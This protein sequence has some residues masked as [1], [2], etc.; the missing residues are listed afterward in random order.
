MQYSSNV[1]N[2][3]PICST[4]TNS[5]ASHTSVD[6]SLAGFVC[7][8][9]CTQQLHILAVQGSILLTL[10]CVKPATEVS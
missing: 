5:S 6:G 7:L 4:T 2:G 3:A 1:F 9:F 8:E 10:K